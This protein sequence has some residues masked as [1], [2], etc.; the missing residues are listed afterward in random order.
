LRPPLLPRK[1]LY[2]LPSLFTLSSVFCG[3]TAIC[4]ASVATKPGELAS[5][6]ALILFAAVFDAFDGRVARLTKTQSEFGL[7]LDSLADAVSFGVAPAFL[8]YRW[9]LAELPGA[10]GEITCFSFVAAGVCRLARF[11]VV[12]LR[13]GNKPGDAIGLPIP[14]AGGLLAS[15]V[16]VHVRAGGGFAEARPA[17]AAVTLALAYLMVSN[18]PYRMFKRVRPTDPRAILAALLL[19]GF[20]IACT[21]WLRA[22]FLLVA[23]LGAYVGWG[24]LETVLRALRERR[25]AVAIPEVMT[26]ELDAPEIE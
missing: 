12:A 21:I 11:N 25:V 19:T 20:G 24:L 10:W 5:A 1:T 23:L 16:I 4:L 14:L 9:G 8:M 22:S 2:L 15:M 13:E 18:V 3:F 26:V 17:L 7:H 6:G